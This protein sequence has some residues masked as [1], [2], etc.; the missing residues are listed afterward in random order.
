MSVR[1][2]RSRSS[3][4]RYSDEEASD[5]EEEEKQGIAVGLNPG[6][7]Q[8]MVADCLARLDQFSGAEVV[9]IEDESDPPD[10]VAFDVPNVDFVST[11]MALELT[12]RLGPL[13]EYKYD[14]PR[15]T[16]R[17]TGHAPRGALASVI[18]RKKREAFDLLTQTEW[19]NWLIGLLALM[20]IGLMGFCGARLWN[21]WD[22]YHEP[23]RALVQ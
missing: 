2:L 16:L 1:G 8:R 13:F 10:L 22:G 23:W 21:L 11:R 7:A 4:R 15:R 18:W 6:A 12:R 5:E 3:F 19:S 9:F 17:I 14:G 20:G